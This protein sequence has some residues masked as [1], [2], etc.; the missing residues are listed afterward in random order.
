MRGGRRAGAFG[1]GAAGAT[2][3]TVPVKALVARVFGTGEMKAMFR[4]VRCGDVRGWDSSDD[5]VA[6]AMR[7]KAEWLKGKMSES[8]VRGCV[9]AYRYPQYMGKG[10]LK[11][12]TS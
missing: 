4:S 10:S 9:G 7:P 5:D 11:A 1:I 2:V 12:G 6:R 3:V 8:K